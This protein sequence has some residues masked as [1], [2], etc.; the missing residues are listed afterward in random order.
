MRSHVDP[1]VAPSRPARAREVLLDPPKDAGKLWKGLGSPADSVLAESI[2]LLPQ[3]REEEPPTEKEPAKHGPTEARAASLGC[4]RE[5]LGVLFRIRMFLER[6][7]ER[8]PRTTLW[9]G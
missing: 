1:G 4:F 5:C 3:L 9:L 8:V 7:S 2:F 6:F